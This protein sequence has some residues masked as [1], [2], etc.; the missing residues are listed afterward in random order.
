MPRTAATTDRTGPAKA[1]ADGDDLN[2]SAAGRVATVLLAFGDRGTSGALTVSEVARHLGRER[3]QVSRMLKVLAASGLL[4]QD[5]ETRAYRL[6]W[7]MYHLAGRAGD[8]RLLALAT[9]A[10]RDLVART[11]ET[12][13]I[14]VLQGNRSFTVARESSMQSVQAGGWVGRTSPLHSCASGRALMLHMSDEDVANLVHGDLQG[15]G[16]G[17]RAPESMRSVIDLIRQ[18]RARGFTVAIDELED[19]LTSVGAPITSATGETLAAINVSGPT[20][21]LA[22]HVEGIGPQLVLTARHVSARMSVA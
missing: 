15:A 4:E 3:S 16:L 13:L 8:Q 11:R 22:R 7:R 14:S 1:P 21:R 20:S 12:A 9:P 10:L 2:S 18:E 17:P 5:Q 6:G 19:G